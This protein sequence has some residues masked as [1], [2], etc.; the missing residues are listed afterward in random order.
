[1][2][3]RAFARASIAFAATAVAVCTAT[4]EPVVRMEQHGPVDNRI[5]VVIL[6]DGYTQAEQTLFQT[7][8]ETFRDVLVATPPFSDYRK[9]FNVKRIFTAS[10][11][12]GASKPEG[13]RNTA[14][15]AAYNCNGIRRLI[16]VD[17]RRVED[18]LARSVAVE[19]R[20]LVVVLVNDPEYGGSGGAYAVTS[21]SQSGA[22]FSDTLMHEIGHAF[23]GL[24]DEYSDDGNC[25]VYTGPYPNVDDTITARISSAKWSR[26]VPLGVVFPS[27]DGAAY[28][29]AFRGANHCDTVWHRPTTSSKMRNNPE[30][31]REV[32]TEE[33]VDQ[34]YWHVL[35]IDG[36]TP[37]V[38]D[39]N[40][41]AGTSTRFAVD[42]ID[43]NLPGMTYTW[44]LDGT[45]VGTTRTIDLDG[46]AFPVGDSHLDVIVEDRS[47][48]S[49]L[50]FL[51]G[52]VAVPFWSVHRAR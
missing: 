15:G 23:G 50:P 14:L 40:V 41:T 10:V 28:V 32:N 25:G 8:A 48:L 4:A 46:R 24:G 22:F 21:A 5:D 18:V 12:S 52:V 39:V 20:D 26:W 11:D 38:I 30:P 17:A 44:R 49:R 42:V 16:C 13:A 35:P 27:P 19:G 7:D 37:D 43:R 1:M 47:P 3:A 34:I 6:G 36:R 45:V 31:Y 51:G 2:I 29:G 33:L 9:Y